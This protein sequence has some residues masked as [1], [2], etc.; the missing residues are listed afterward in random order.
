M[1]YGMV[2]GITILIDVILFFPYRNK[3]RLS[4]LILLVLMLMV[5]FSVRKTPDIANY[6]LNFNFGSTSGKDPAF[7][8]LLSIFKKGGATYYNFQDWYFLVALSLIS[9]GLIRLTDHRT[10]IYILFFF[11]PFLL[12]LVQIRNFMAMALLVFAIGVCYSNREKFSKRILWC[13]IVGLAATQH[14]AAM[15]YIPFALFWDKKKALRFLV[16]ASSIFTAVLFIGPD[17]LLNILARF[18]SFAIDSERAET[19]GAR[20]THFGLFVMVAQAVAMMLIAKFSVRFAN[21]YNKLPTRDVALKRVDTAP[22]TFTFDLLCYSAIFWPFYLLNGNFTRLTQNEF[23]L[24]FM[25]MALLLKYKAS[26]HGRK[27]FGAKIVNPLTFSFLA[28]APLY[29]YSLT[30]IWSTHYQDVVIPIMRGVFN[31]L[32]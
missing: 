18:L 26:L 2:M 25:C 24:I 22:L 28:F 10:L 15:A 16:I 7:A 30:T 17:S 5:A 14:A 6:I 9:Y 31:G 8:F 12:N 23:L 3:I 13:L 32:F 20:S 19:Y 11:Y 29:I 1:M 21:E 27:D 4:N